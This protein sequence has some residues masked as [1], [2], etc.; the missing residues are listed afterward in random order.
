MNTLDFLKNGSGIHI[1]KKNRGKFTK[2]AKAAGES[3]QEH[4]RKVL[5]N[6][7]ATPLQKKRANFARNVAKWKHK[8]GG[9]IKAQEGT[10]TNFFTK[11]SN[12]FSSNKDLVSNI[13]QIGTNL[14][15][16]LKQN[17][18]IDS[19]IEANNAQME[20]DKAASWMNNYKKAL[21]QQTDRSDI[22]NSHNAFQIANSAD[23]SNN[24][25][26]KENLKLA[27]SKTNPTGDFLSSLG[28]IVSNFFTKKDSTTPAPTTST[29][30]TST[31]PTTFSTPTTDLGNGFSY[32]L[33]T[34]MTYKPNWNSMLKYQFGGKY[35][36]PSIKTKYGYPVYWSDKVPYEFDWANKFLKEH[37]G[38]TG[39]AAGGGAQGDDEDDPRVI[40]RNSH[41]NIITDH[42]DK[43]WDG[44]DEIEAIRH[45]M[46][47][48]N[49]HPNFKISPEQETFRKTNFSEN[50][51]YN[52]DDDAW[53]QSVI[54]RILVGDMKGTP[55]QIK[56][57]DNFY[58]KFRKQKGRGYW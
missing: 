27:Q 22:V 35:F 24:K 38:V 51:P 36:Q 16:G 23:Y 18:A 1:K 40:I 58:E 53:R 4:A 13:G 43:R 28:G 29:S 48:T 50:D 3:V 25:L 52:T 32:N 19:Q 5:A 54:S 31:T 7:N 41:S 14:I 47:E 26:Q 15:S 34:G 6:P 55:E 21:L 37:P 9:I 30:I 56:E 11:T 20:A 46:N 42:N 57:A 12:W 2:S 39:F 17:K 8:D 45:F 49:Y 33:N 44:L 10:K